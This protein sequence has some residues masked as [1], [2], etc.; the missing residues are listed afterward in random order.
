M[1]D[2][3]NAVFESISSLDFNVMNTA[4]FAAKC[5]S[6]HAVFS[7]YESLM[8]SGMVISKNPDQS[9]LYQKVASGQMP[10]GGPMLSDSE[11]KAIFNWISA[12]APKAVAGGTPTP[13]GTQ[14]PPVTGTPTT[15]P[16]SGTPATSA[17]SPTFAWIQANV[18]IPRCTICHRGASAPAGFDLSSYDNVMMGGRVVAGNPSA[19]LLFQR[20]NNNTMPPGNPLSA[21]VK[22]LISQWIQNGAK[23]DAPA[24]GLPPGSTPQLPELPPLA[25]NFNSIMAN[26]IGPRCLACHDTTQRKGGVVLQDYRSLMLEVRAFDAGSSKL[27]KEIEDNNMPQSGGPLNFQQ[28]ETIRQWINSG[29]RP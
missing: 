7:S 10:K 12:G 8:A 14:A 25:P 20:I 23:N 17:P 6:C 1:P 27:Y 18:L 13:P 11:V 3:E 9:P 29:A 2:S 24:G 5:A 19:S 26:I 21:D 4:V 22:L 28:K 15:P 16:T